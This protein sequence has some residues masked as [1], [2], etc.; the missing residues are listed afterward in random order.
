MIALQS[1]QA[2]AA[3]SQQDV[4]DPA[5][6]PGDHPEGERDPAVPARLGAANVGNRFR[7]EDE[8]VPRHHVEAVQQDGAACKQAWHLSKE[9]THFNRALSGV[10]QFSSPPEAA[11]PPLK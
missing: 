11:F 5:Q 2:T 4:A 3:S 7:G 9:A 8:A 6:E 10:F 1:T